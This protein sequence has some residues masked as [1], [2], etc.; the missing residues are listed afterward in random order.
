MRKLISAS[1]LAVI[2][3]FTLMSCDLGDSDAPAYDFELVAID[4]VDMPET[5]AL[6]TTREIK[7]YYRRPTA[8]HFYDGFYYEKNLNVRTVALQMRVLAGQTCQPLQEEAATASF[9]FY[10]SN[11]GSYTFKFYKGK[12]SSG[13]NLFLEYQ[14]PVTGG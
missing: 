13:N 7:V 3:V 5:V 10:V 4:S 9:N 11:S 12:D 6:G 8:C 1:I 14:V 2:A